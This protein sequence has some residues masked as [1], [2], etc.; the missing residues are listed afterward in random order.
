MGGSDCEEDP[1]IEVEEVPHG[2]L[3]SQ[4][5]ITGSKNDEPPA[6]KALPRACH[7]GASKLLQV[8]WK[9]VS[10]REEVTPPPKAN[11]PRAHAPTPKPRRGKKAAA[12]VPAP[13]KDNKS[14]VLPETHAPKPE[15]PPLP[16]RA[17]DNP[18]EASRSPADDWG[19]GVKCDLD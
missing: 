18:P 6:P 4:S 2:D 1:A 15:Q 8:T 11:S 14:G 10:L 19:T 3:L 16:K 7:P 12:P 13:E 9:E 17:K 5:D